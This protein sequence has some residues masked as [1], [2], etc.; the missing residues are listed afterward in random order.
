MLAAVPRAADAGRAHAR[1]RGH[2]CCWSPTR[3]SCT[4]S[5]SCSRAARASASR[6][7]G[8][9]LA[10]GCAG[11]VW[12]RETAGDDPRRPARRRAGAAPGVRVGPAGVAARQPLGRPARRAADD[13]G[14]GGGRR[15]RARRRPCRPASR[16]RSRSR[17]RV[18]A[19]GARGRAMA[20]QVPVAVD[21]SGACGLVALGTLVAGVVRYRSAMAP[22][23]R[24]P[25]YAQRPPAGARGR[26]ASV[27]RSH[28]LTTRTL[29]MGILNRTPDSFYDHGATFALDDL[30]RASRAARDRG[31]RPPRRR[32]RE[33]RAGPGGR[34]GRGAGPGRADDRGAARPPR[35][36][37]SRSTPGGLRCSTR[38]AGPA[39]SSATTSAASPTRIPRG[40]GRARRVGRRDAHPAAPARPRPRAALR[41][42]LG[43]VPAFLLDRA[44][45]AEAAGLASDQIAIDAGLD[46]G[47]TPAMS[48]VLLRESDVLAS[49]RVHAAALGVEQAVPRR[50]ARPRDRRP[51]GR[52]ARR[53][54]LRR[55]A[56]LP[57]RAGPRRR[58]ERQGL[59]D[60]RG[61][62]AGR[63]SR[64]PG[65]GVRSAVSV[66]LVKGDDP[67]LR[68]DALEAVLTETLR[69]RRPDPRARGLQDPGPRELRGRAPVAPTPASRPSRRCVNAA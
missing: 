14:P 18:L 59:P 52:V 62:P 6:R 7:F 49:S 55:R 47:K 21:A 67:I 45:R 68:A 25:A 35:R 5:G 28:D 12:L 31:R 20:S 16:R 66:H 43:D 19:G 24:R 8:P 37:R 69:R 57:H 56:R 53:R 2:A 15:R 65:V 1:A 63:A 64:S 48:A 54:R 26:S 41:R 61:D 36:R 4:R 27:T 3:S 58:R 42:P 17:P 32:R 13:L 46:L 34:R 51:P 22:W 10:R 23:E 29:V 38:P 40:R 60:D 44:A 30:L 9:V 50:A 39:P 11:R 33:G